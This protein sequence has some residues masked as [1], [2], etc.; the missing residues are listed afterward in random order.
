VALDFKKIEEHWQR[1]YRRT[2]RTIK[3]LENM[4]YNHIRSENHFFL[5][6]GKEETSEG[7]T[8]TAFKYIKGSSREEGNMLCSPSIANRS[9]SG[10]MVQQYSSIRFVMVKH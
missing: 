7:G 5:P 2:T 1:D 4:V 3:S 9:R 10:V 8:T 6:Y